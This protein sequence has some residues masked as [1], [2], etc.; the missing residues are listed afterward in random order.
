MVFGEWWKVLAGR[1]GWGGGLMGWQ[2][3]GLDWRRTSS[4][5][6]YSLGLVCAYLQFLTLTHTV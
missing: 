3:G 4:C 1:L 6:R 5:G 2:S